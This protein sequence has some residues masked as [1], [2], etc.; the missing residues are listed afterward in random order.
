MKHRKALW[1]SR[2]LMLMLMLM[3]CV[4]RQTLVGPNG[5]WPR[6]AGSGSAAISHSV[7]LTPN[8]S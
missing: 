4:G 1:E 2:V 8:V 3:L 6:P 5:I 7:T